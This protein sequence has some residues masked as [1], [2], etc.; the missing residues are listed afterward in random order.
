MQKQITHAFEETHM[1]TDKGSFHKA[2][3]TYQKENSEKKHFIPTKE[4]VETDIPRQR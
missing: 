4:V 1:H 2:L 3:A